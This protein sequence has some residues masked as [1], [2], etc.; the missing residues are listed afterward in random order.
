MGLGQ[1]PRELLADGDLTVGEDERQI[2]VERGQQIFF[3]GGK[4]IGGVSAP[5]IVRAIW[6]TTVS[7]PSG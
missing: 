4:T 5:K 7:Y 3:S 2:G 6:E 1:V